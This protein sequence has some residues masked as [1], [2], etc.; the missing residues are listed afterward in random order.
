MPEKLTI[1]QITKNVQPGTASYSELTI[2]NL[3]VFSSKLQRNETCYCND[4]KTN[5]TCF[6]FEKSNMPQDII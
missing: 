4:F 6:D 2:I 5:S 1:R 3:L